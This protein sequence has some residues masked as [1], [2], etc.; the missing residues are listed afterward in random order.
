MLF[1]WRTSTEKNTWGI[2]RFPCGSTAFLYLLLIS[3]RCYDTQERLFH[4]FKKPS[5]LLVCT[6]RCK[7]TFSSHFRLTLE[8]DYRSRQSCWQQLLFYWIWRVINFSDVFLLKFS[9]FCYHS[10]KGGSSKNS[11]DSVWL[12]DPKNPV[13]CKNVGPMLNLTR[14]IVNFVWKFADFRYHGNRG[15]SGTK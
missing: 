4:L 5:S 3:N 15:W 6:R 10:N 9:N 13:W 14:F 8:F 11:N 2:A 1:N 12:A 7:N